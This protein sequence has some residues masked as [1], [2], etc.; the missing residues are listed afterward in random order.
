[1]SEAPGTPHAAEWTTSTTATTSST[2]TSL[3]P[4]STTT[5]TLPPSG[6]ICFDCRN[7]R[8]ER[9]WEVPLCCMPQGLTITQARVEPRKDLLRVKGTLAAGAFTGLDP[10][11]QAVELEIRDA[12]GV[13][14]CCMIP[15]T[16]WRKGLGGAYWFR[17]PKRRLRPELESLCLIVP[18]EGGRTRVVVNASAQAL[19]APLLDIRLAAAQQCVRGEARPMRRGGG[20]SPGALR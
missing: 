11:Q 4:S 14:V 17:D 1:M 2:T 3:A 12:A 16:E 20:T 7:R 6:E 18:P 13:P 8:D 9:A 15:P 10:R 19:D 5:T